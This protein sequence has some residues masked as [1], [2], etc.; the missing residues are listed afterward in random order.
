MTHGHDGTSTVLVVDDDADQLAAWALRVQALGHRCLTAPS[1]DHALQ[2]LHGRDPRVDLVLC[3]LHFGDHDPRGGLRV[4]RAAAALEA[5]IVPVIMLTAYGDVSSAV[6]GMQAGAVS[7]IEKGRPGDKTFELI[8]DTMRAALRQARRSQAELDRARALQESWNN[9]AP[10]AAGGWWCGS[11][12]LVS[13]A[14]ARAVSGD[15][16]WQQACPESA[17]VTVALGD[18]CGHD[19][20]AAL[21]AARFRSDLAFALERDKRPER[22]LADVRRRAHYVGTATLVYA[23]LAG[24]GQVSYFS[25]GHPVALWLHRDGVR[26]LLPTAGLLASGLPLPDGT[27]SLVA[28]VGDRLLLYSDGAAERLEGTRGHGAAEPREGV[29]LLAELLRR[30]RALPAPQ[31]LE[32]LTSAVKSCSA[33]PLD[34]D[35]TLLLVERTA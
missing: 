25:A 17:A 9:P 1:V 18:M 26:P 33:E 2:V 5:Q 15:V 34:D 32:A 8:Q 11:R 30:T 27:A 20:A 12:S 10:L 13:N 6:E 29:D 23:L 3:D 7:F 22:V 31:A 14:R 4:V 28:D 16:V 24:G 19:V 35:V 21:L